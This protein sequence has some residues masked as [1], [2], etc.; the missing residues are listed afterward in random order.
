MA[1]TRSARKGRGLVTSFTAVCCNIA[2]PITAQYSVTLQD[3][4]QRSILS[5]SALITN[6]NRKLQGVKQLWNHKQLLQQWDN[7]EIISKWNSC[8]TND[9]SK[10]YQTPSLSCRTG[11]GHARLSISLS[12]M[13]YPCTYLHRLLDSLHSFLLGHWE[14]SEVLHYKAV[15]FRL[16]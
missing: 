16:L 5:L 3:Q 13:I 15:R 11:G 4:S 12:H 8:A 14:R 1:T 6:F 7:Y 10:S 2:G 9:C